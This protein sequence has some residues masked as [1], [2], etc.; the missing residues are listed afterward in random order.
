[1]FDI[2]KIRRDFP[3][4]KQKING[5]ELVYLDSAAT[6]QK[7]IQ[8]IKAIENYYLTT[9]ANIHRG[10]HFLSERATLAYENARE[11]MRNFINANSTKEIIFVRGCTE[12]INLVAASFGRINFKENDEIIISNAEH[13]SNIVPWQLICEQTHAKLRIIN[14]NDAGEIDLEH[15]QMLLNDRTKLVAVAHVSNV[16]G[17]LNPIKQMIQMAHEI[18]VPVLIDGAQSIPHIPVDVKDLDCDFYTIS[19]H[20]MYAP[21]GIG[22]LYGKEKFLEQMP[23]YQGGG[24]MISRVTFEKT[25]YADLPLKFEAGTPNIEGTIGLG[26]AIDYLSLLGMHSIAKH[27]D[28]LM[29]YGTEKLSDIPGLRIIG[30]AQNKVA[31][32]SFVIDKIHPHDVA[33]VLNSQNHVGIRA[34]H[35]CAMPLM[36]RFQIPATAR[37]SFG[38][39]N[40][41][42]D[43]D[44]LVV[45]IEKVKKFFR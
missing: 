31:V 13:H 20:K 32:I 26:V 4:L 22:V 40:N 35:H 18:N 19:G 25:D 30:T 43:I 5:K 1:M 9:N 2:A 42:A 41:K 15:Y 28:E 45:G 24:S 39:Y 6:S 8:V 14:I 7:P 21:T 33:T 11:K 27:G 34:G 10:V 44:A 16:L 38:L 12:A 17:T 36:E 23:P 3:I 29:Q 37:A